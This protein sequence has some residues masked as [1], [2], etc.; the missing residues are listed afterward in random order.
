MP[1]KESQDLGICTSQ[2]APSDGSRAHI[3]SRFSYV[4][5]T[6]GPALGAFLIWHPLP[7][8]QTF[9]QKHHEMHSVAAA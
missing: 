4:G 7:Q 5:F 6:L 8:I 9:G 1:P 2:T 3:F